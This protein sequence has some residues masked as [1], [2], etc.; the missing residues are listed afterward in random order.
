M[1]W[2]VS[3]AEPI[4]LAIINSA[5]SAHSTVGHNQ[6]LVI[7]SPCLSLQH[8]VKHIKMTIKPKTLAILTSSNVL[9][10]WNSS[11]R[12]PCP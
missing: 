6:I 12:T 7:V 5:V 1:M 3:E 10:R 2:K 8:G 4:W 11:E 9:R